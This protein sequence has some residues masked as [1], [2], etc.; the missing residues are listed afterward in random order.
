MHHLVQ[1]KNFADV[2][3][4]L[5]QPVTLLIGRNGAGKSNVIEG[6]ELL[7][8][9]AQGRSI[10]QISDV[11]RGSGTT[12]EIRGGLLNCPRKIHDSDKST[13]N[14]LSKRQSFTL[15]FFAF[16]DGWHMDYRIEVAVGG[17]SP[18]PY[19]AGERMEWGSRVLFETV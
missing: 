2:E 5:L 15:G 13:L 17:S 19:I 7:A 3:I 9:L 1:F 18:Q 14:H 8:N 16:V 11:G 12:F 10:H 6:V 4:N